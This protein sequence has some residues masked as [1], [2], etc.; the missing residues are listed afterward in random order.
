MHTH[1]IQFSKKT[2]CQDDYIREEMFYDS[3]EIDYSQEC[4]DDSEKEYV[5]DLLCLSLKGCCTRQGHVFTYNGGCQN[6]LNE[7]GNDI[8]K[9]VDNLRENNINKLS[10]RE[11]IRSSLDDPLKINVFFH[12]KDWRPY[13]HRS[14]EFLD[15]LVNLNPGEKFYIGNILD[16]HI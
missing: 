5:M 3:H 8:K 12:G 10:T 1:I 6:I 13:L 16:C 7:W 4:R 15:F 9:K 11:D 14:D 2:I